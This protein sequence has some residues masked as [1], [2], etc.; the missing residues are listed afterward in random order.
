MCYSI[1]FRQVAVRHMAKTLDIYIDDIEVVDMLIDFTINVFAKD[2][3]KEEINEL[4]FYGFGMNFLEILI[5]MCSQ[6]RFLC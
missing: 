2:P 4:V 6:A 5:F 1:I 3:G